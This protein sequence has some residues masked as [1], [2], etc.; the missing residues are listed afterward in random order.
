MFFFEVVGYDM[1][2]SPGRGSDYL[3]VGVRAQ[4]DTFG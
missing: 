1:P 3:V 2:I 4:G